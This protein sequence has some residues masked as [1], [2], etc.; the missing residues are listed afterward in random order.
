MHDHSDCCASHPR[1]DFLLGVAGAAGASLAISG[2]AQAAGKASP[3]TAGRAAAGPRIDTHAHLWPVEYLDFLEK[4]GS[5]GTPVARNIRA[6]DSAEDLKA[7]FAMMDAAGVQMQVLSASPQ[8]LQTED[9]AACLTA[10]KMINDTYARLVGQYP[11]R[12]MAY[13]AVPLPHVDEAIAEARRC[14]EELGFLGI[15][16]NTL[17]ANKT[18]ADPAYL[19]FYAEMDR[20]G[21]VIYIHPTG[22]G[23]LSPMVN[24]FRLEWVVGAPFEDSLAA[25]QLLKADIPHKFPNIKFHVAHLGGVVAFLMQRIE[26]N[27]TGWK[28]FPRS[29]TAELKKMWFDT[30]NFHGPALRCIADT[31]GTDK[32]L[33]G[34][35]FPY[36]QD[37]LYTRIVTYIEESKLP[38]ETCEAIL[39]GNV[40]RL[41]DLEKKRT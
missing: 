25:L 6:T 13:G 11:D 20:L 22:C 17:V 32:L 18:I 10:A 30:A 29:P 37:E 2:N 4:N 21:A 19:P 38:R 23:T 7:R 34:S 41:Y 3:A 36:F 15:S 40:R 26:D 5:T 8:I 12:F 35:D 14:V 31:F 39:S 16:L 1:R 9:A 27:Y 24:D 28:A 33:L